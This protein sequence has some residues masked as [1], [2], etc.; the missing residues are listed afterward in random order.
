MWRFQNYIIEFLFIIIDS[1]KIR[2]NQ[3]LKC[4]IFMIYFNLKVI[5]VILYPQKTENENRN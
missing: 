2:K 1:F 5:I 3:K 4:F